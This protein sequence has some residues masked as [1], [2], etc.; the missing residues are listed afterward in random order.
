MSKLID[1]YSSLEVVSQ[2]EFNRR[3]PGKNTIGDVVLGMGDL[4]ESLKEDCG[5]SLRKIADIAGVSVAGLDRWR[6][7]G[8]GSK[9]HCEKLMSYCEQRLQ[10]TDTKNETAILPS[11][12]VADSLRLC[13]PAQLEKVI[14]E[15]LQAR[16]GFPDSLVCT[17]IKM[18][19]G[20]DGH[21]L[22]IVVR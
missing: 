14:Q 20:T 7:N 15:A 12:S 1:T 5:L 3:F 8:Y 22:E 4:V 17:L 16:L 13:S 2:G 19:A 10:V 6:N 9:K 21:R 18:E 11:A